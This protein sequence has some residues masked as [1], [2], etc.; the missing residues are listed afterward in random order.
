MNNKLENLIYPES[1]VNRFSR[2]SEASEILKSEFIGLDEVIDNIIKSVTP[3]YITPEIIER[4][5]VISMFGLTG[6]GKTS[7]VRR[8]VNLLGLA[9]KSIFFDCGEESNESSTTGITDKI[10]ESLG[11]DYSS[12]TSN[13]CI[14]DSVFIFDEFQYARTIDRS[15][16]EIIKP[17]LRVIW[18][19][20][21]NGIINVIDYKYDVTSFLTFLEDFSVFAKEHSNIKVVNGE[22][23]D[24]SDVKTLLT[25]LGLFYYDRDINKLLGK[26]VSQSK[27]IKPKIND[28]EESEEDILAPIRILDNRCMRAIVMR[29]NS[30]SP[31]EGYRKIAELNKVTTIGEF[32]EILSKMKNVLSSPRSMDCSK[33]LV[34]IL[35]NLDEAFNT[36]QSDLSADVDADT[37]YDQVKNVSISD[38]KE[39]L[40]SRFRSEQIA[41]LGNNLI[42]YPALSKENFKKIIEKELTRISDKFYELE[43]IKI[44][45]S[46]GIKDLMYSEGVFPSQGVRPIF[47]TIG[48]FFT[49]LLSNILTNKDRI[50]NNVVEIKIKSE[51]IEK[52]DFNIKEISILIVYS[53]GEPEEIVIPLQL[54]PLR[55]PERRLT[56]YCNAVHET[57]H[58][59]VYLHET[60]EYPI[61]IVAISSGDGGFCETYNKT[62][63]GEIQSREEIDS[64]VKVCLAGYCAENLVFGERPE[65]CLMGSSSDIEAAWETLSNAAYECGYFIPFRFANDTVTTS[66][67]GIP[68]GIGDSDS[69]NMNMIMSHKNLKSSIDFKFIELMSETKKI[70]KDEKEL[71]KQVSLELGK[72]GSMSGNRFKEL[73]EEYG[74]RLT[75]EFIE[76]VKKDK[77]GEWYLEKLSN[78]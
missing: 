1:R 66:S 7:L 29:Y 72:S 55:N 30:I 67:D 27:P 50:S 2:L 62:K 33:S 69:D 39:A 37:F 56:R 78:L 28:D 26:S 32:Y 44:K 74:N 9:G 19:I 22:I 36:V 15:G 49:P 10:S 45:M 60:G 59:I 21:D 35:G 48:S 75:S 6:V 58:A 43:G 11:Y 24:R 68:F 25:S 46:P 71:L 47:T 41:R 16:E 57:G 51:G 5:V 38:I 52:L 64:E 4:P 63:D 18:N 77:S 76:S 31:G 14:K 54:G 3:W 61:N 12:N 23:L 20:I 73:V 40:K 34:F 42:K 53:K 70:L 8:L 65:K 13:D 17:T